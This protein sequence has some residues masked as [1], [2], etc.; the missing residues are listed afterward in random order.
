MK[1]QRNFDILPVDGDRRHMVGGRK[2]GG[3]V[4]AKTCK[5]PCAKT[6]WGTLHMT[7]GQYCVKIKLPKFN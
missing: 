7:V 3:R 1:F 6:V 2:E 4:P 5:G